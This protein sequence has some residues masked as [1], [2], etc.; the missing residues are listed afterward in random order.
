MFKG[1]HFPRAVVLTCIRWYLRFKLSYRDIE[2]LMEERGVQVDHA[3]INRW[4]VKFSPMLLLRSRRHKKPVG[5][6]WRMDEPFIKVRGEWKYLYRAVDKQGAT[7]DCL[8]TARR[9]TDSALRFLRRAVEHNGSP[10]KINIDCSGANAAGIAAY[11]EE[12]AAGIEIRQCKYLNNIVEQD[13][14][15]V[16]Q[17]MVAALGFKTFYTAQATLAGIELVHMIRL[18]LTPI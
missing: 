6:S 3:T 8:L 13:H 5:T 1:C 17:K 10:E 11:N 15:F 18:A 7:I 14:R 12:A 2:E 16:T 9:D 4:V